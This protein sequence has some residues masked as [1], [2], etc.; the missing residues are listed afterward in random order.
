[1]QRS[2]LAVKKIIVSML[3]T[4]YKALLYF[5]RY[6]KV[7]RW[8][9]CA[10]YPA[11]GHYLNKTGRPILYSCEWPLYMRALGATVITAQFCQW[12]YCAQYGR[13]LAWHCRLSVC[14]SVC[15]GV[16]WRSWSVWGWKLHRRASRRT[17]PILFFRHF[18]YRMYR[19]AAIAL[20]CF[21]QP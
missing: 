15:D 14:L 16:L 7:G 8:L 6:M 20:G 4:Q 11:M 5:D 10:G 17:L 3:F 1:M 18:C 21:V 19:L 13:L 2:N 12:Y 9:F